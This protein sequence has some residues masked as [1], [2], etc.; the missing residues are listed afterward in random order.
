LSRHHVA[1]RHD[2]RY[3]EP[4]GQSYPCFTSWNHSEATFVPRWQFA[5]VGLANSAAE[6]CASCMSLATQLISMRMKIHETCNRMLAIAFALST[7]MA[8]AKSKHRTHHRLK[9]TDVFRP[10]VVGRCRR[11][12]VRAGTRH[13]RSGRYARTERRKYTCH[14]RSTG[15]RLKS[16]GPALNISGTGPSTS[17]GG[18]AGGGGGGGGGGRVR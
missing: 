13:R 4:A 14:D 18:A 11:K 10:E 6:P 15:L 3:A 5:T 1:P 9:G 12:V 17:G 7:L 16:N 8:C 2:R